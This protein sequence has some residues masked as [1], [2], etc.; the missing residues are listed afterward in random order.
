[1]PNDKERTK[2]KGKKR[3]YEKYKMRRENVLYRRI[4]KRIDKVRKSI[5]KWTKQKQKRRK[6]LRE[7]DQ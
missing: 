7:S 5:A 1:M 3:A 4:K 6:R 2:E